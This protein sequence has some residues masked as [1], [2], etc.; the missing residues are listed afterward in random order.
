MPFTVI[1]TRV[2]VISK[3]IEHRGGH[4]KI[5]V[6]ISNSV[7]ECIAFE[8]TKT[9]R[10]AVRELLI[11][12]SI[13]IHGNV[14]NNEFGLHIAL[15]FFSIAH[16]QS[17]VRVSSPLC[18]CGKRMTSAGKFKGYKC[19][20]CNSKS[21]FAFRKVVPRKLFL[22]QKVYASLS[23]QRHLTRPLKRIHLRNHDP[24]YEI[25]YS[26]FRMKFD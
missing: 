18:S 4:V 10:D 22:G 14:K 15:E 17:D 23:A 13:F 20:D 8:P 7:I 2:T 12:D 5:Q 21:I 9:L 11:G 24:G 6:R 25:D 1:S 26:D 19:K 3:P 16:L